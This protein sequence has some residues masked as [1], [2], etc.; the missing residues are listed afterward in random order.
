M[1]D[2]VFSRCLVYFS[3]QSSQLNLSSIES[4][5]NMQILKSSLGCMSPHENKTDNCINFERK[6]IINTIAKLQS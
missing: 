2:V 5:Q 4:S 6:G 3:A 1:S